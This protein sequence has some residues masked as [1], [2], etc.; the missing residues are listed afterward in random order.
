MAAMGIQVLG[1]TLSVIGWLGTILCCGLPMWRVTAFIG[2]NIVVAQIIWDGLW[3]SCV[4]QSTGQMQCKVYESMLALAQDMQAARAL[5]IIAIVLAV[6]GIFFAIIGGKCTNCVEDESTKAKIV[7]FSGIIFILSGIMLLI[8]LCWTANTIIR[9]FYNPMV[10]ESQKREL[11]ASL[12]IG[13]ASCGL[14][15]LGGTLLCC[16]CPPKNEKQYSAKYTAARSMP[17]SNYV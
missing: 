12:Y 7:I 17:T 2:N 8:P 13:W 11:G 9:D 14:L 6:V 4:V 3:M 10:T 16:N 5:V 15:L 1:I